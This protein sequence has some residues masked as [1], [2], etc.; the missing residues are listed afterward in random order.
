VPLLGGGDP[1]PS[2]PQ[3]LL[4]AGT[5]GAGKTTLAR[6]VAEVLGHPHVELDSLHHGPGWT[7]RSQFEDDV[8]RLAAGDT[9][10]SEWQYAAVREL[11]LARADCLVW[12]DLSR[13]VVMTRVIRRT[14]SRR[15]HRTVLWNGNVEPPFRTFLTDR[16]HIVRWAWRTHAH[17]EERVL[18]ALAARPDLTVVRLRSAAEVTGW[19]ARLSRGTASASAP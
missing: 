12:L 5:S 15:I 10:V 4:V 1:L 7:K 2:R 8:R 9:W 19:L 13:R 16:D 6:A 14:L 17:T 11:L 18:A 3:R